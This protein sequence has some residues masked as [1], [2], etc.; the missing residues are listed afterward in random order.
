MPTFFH[1]LKWFPF[2]R[3]NSTRVSARRP[4]TERKVVPQNPPLIEN[5]GK[6]FRTD[7]GEGVG[8]AEFFL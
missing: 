2:A 3:K 7:S 1:P 4:R 6:Y 5:Y 8:A